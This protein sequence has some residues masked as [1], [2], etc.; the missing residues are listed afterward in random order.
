MNEP[1][2]AY[3]LCI[4]EPMKEHSVYASLCK[5]PVIEEVDPLFGEWDLII[6]MTAENS[7]DFSTLV[8]ENINNIDGILTTKT[9]M[10]Y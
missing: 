1:A 2:I 8:P 7:E 3:I 5:N 9:L 4:V 6:K 10:G